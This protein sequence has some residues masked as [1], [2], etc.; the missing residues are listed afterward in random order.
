MG[1]GDE[2]AVRR[3]TRRRWSNVFVALLVP[4]VDGW[5]NGGA[6]ALL[7]HHQEFEEP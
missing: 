3:P 4:V 1:L 7:A 6:G 2:Q 5:I